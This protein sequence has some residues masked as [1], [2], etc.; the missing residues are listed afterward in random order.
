MKRSV[1]VVGSATVS[2]AP[3]C[4]RLTCGVQ[5]S[6][7]NAQ[8][9]LRRSNEALVAILAALAEQGVAA[10]DMR[11]NG[12]NL[13]PTEGGYNGSND[14]TVIVREIGL[15]G[16]V[17]DAVAAAG[18]PNLTLHG[19]SFSVT[20]PAG[21]LREARR[22]AVEAAR[23]IAEELAAASGAAVGEVLTINES[24]GHHAP[25]AVARMAKMSMTPVEPGSQELRVDVDVTYRLVDPD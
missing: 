21:H 1:S 23:A 11:T 9:A 19:V 18:G 20:D 13:Y 16:S 12:P 25:V 10:A 15:V 17:I 24:T 2:V 3:D 4:A 6:G 5:V 22:A 7:V 8:D 14:V